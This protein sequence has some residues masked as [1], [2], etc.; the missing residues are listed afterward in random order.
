M[1]RMRSFL[2][3]RQS[4][5]SVVMGYRSD[6]QERFDRGERVSVLCW[7]QSPE[8]PLAKG[9]MYRVH[10]RKKFDQDPIVD[11]TMRLVQQGV[12]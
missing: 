6:C 10:A 5:P 2:E 8:H 11:A 12:L 4:E 9:F 3:D 1:R 7:V